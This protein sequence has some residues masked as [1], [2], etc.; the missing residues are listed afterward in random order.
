M[1]SRLTVEL[2][3]SLEFDGIFLL[4]G[5]ITHQDEELRNIGRIVELDDFKLISYNRPQLSYNALY[6]RG[7]KRNYD[8]LEFSETFKEYQKAM[9]IVR[10]IEKVV[11]R[12]EGRVI[13]E[14]I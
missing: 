10:K 3:V 4:K 6:I 8:N 5:H 7:N 13:V 2:S 9:E 1:D 14:I 11:E 12:V